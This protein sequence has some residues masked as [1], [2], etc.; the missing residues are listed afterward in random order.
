MILGVEGNVNVGKTTF[1]EKYVKENNLKILKETPFLTDACPLLRQKYY[2]NSEIK[3]KEELNSDFA[4]MDRTII[5]VY[6]FTIISKEF[7]KK[8]R[9]FII[10]DIK[11]SI[12]EN[13]II[14][15]DRLIF[16]LYPFDLINEK[17]NIL[18]HKKHTQSLLVD[19]DYYIKYTL[20]FSNVLKNSKEKILEM[21][22]NRQVL[23]F[24]DTKIYQNLCKSYIEPNSVIILDGAPAI[25]KTTIGNLQ[26]KYCY[27][28]EQHYKKYSLSDMSNQIESIIKRINLL[29][30]NKV[31]LD[32]SF[33]MGIT[34]LFYSHERDLT[35]N[36]K[37]D[38]IQKIM[39]NIPMFLYITK[40]VYLYTDITTLEQ[41]KN[42]DMTK[43]REHFEDNIKYLNKEI[44]FYKTLDK[45]MQGKSNIFFV[46]ASKS[47]NDIIKEIEAKKEKT[48]LLIDLFYYIIEGIK[49][50]EI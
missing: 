6:L 5:S 7:T 39:Q 29:R 11:K 30:K 1:I 50:G 35:K 23:L 41:R 31:L 42:G 33:L 37:L 27:I 17:H 32:T 20:F 48:L 4:V 47:S 49:R 8:E 36:E 22:D 12:Q 21:Q 34:H 16:I 9:D 43:K 3:K 24:E 25:G 26:T 15:P 46:E 28:P 44:N 45:L 2:I 38:I 13:K 14:I 40:I 18:G 19:Y 10:K